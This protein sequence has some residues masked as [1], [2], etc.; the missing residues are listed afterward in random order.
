MNRCRRLLSALLTL[1][2]LS[3]GSPA[4]FPAALAADAPSALSEEAEPAAESE[5]APA[6]I[7]LTVSIFENV[8]RRWLL[9]PTQLSVPEGSGLQSLLLVLSQYAFL[10]DAE[11][12]GNEILSITDEDGETFPSNPSIGN[13][14]ILI[15]NGIEYG[16]ED[17][18]T[19]PSAF[20]SGDTIQLVYESGGAAETDLSTVSTPD[21]T[22]STATGSVPW[23]DRYD[24]ALSTGSNWLR[25]NAETPFALTVLGACGEAVDHR[26]LTRI[27]RAINEDT[28][29]TGTELAEDI[30]AVSFS[31]ISAENFSGRD[32]IA[33]MLPYPDLGRIESILGLIAYDCNQYDIPSDALNARSAML[34]VIMAGQ[35]ADGG[36]AETQ[37]EDSD[38]ILTALALISLAPYRDD[39]TVGPC[40]ERALQWLAGEMEDGCLYYN[41]RL[42]SCTATSAVILALASLSVPLTDER[43][44]AGDTNLLSALMGFYADGTGFSERAGRTPTA[45]ATGMALLALE[46]QRTGR[47]P[48]ILSSRITGN[49]SIDFTVSESSAESSSS[50]P[51]LDHE[52]RIKVQVGLVAAVCGAAVAALAMLGVLLHWRQKYK[53]KK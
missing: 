6:S 49:G 3:G 33:E 38:V 31:G 15:V 17:S 44:C 8:S 23:E 50:E 12:D 11:T 30:L 42:P 35:N 14:W 20:Q 5:S 24:S 36:I 10:E 48:L 34:N 41:Q 22:L 47:N 43:F 46:S 4:A 51:L 40:I 45:E 27:L 28:S 29:P 1:L 32:L 9:S 37:G 19:P 2:L 39:D 26:Y 18:L 7:S 16:G 52:T 25:Q 21:R 53:K 13:N